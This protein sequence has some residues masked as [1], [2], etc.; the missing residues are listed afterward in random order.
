MKPRTNRRL[1]VILLV[2]TL[3]VAG[4]IAAPL[5]SE[6]R[7]VDEDTDRVALDGNGD[8]EGHGQP[9][10]NGNDSDRQ[11]ENTANHREEQLQRRIDAVYAEMSVEERIAQLLLLG[12]PGQDP[13]EKLMRWVEERG[14]GGVKVFGWNGRN[15]QRLA[16]TLSQ[17]Q[18]AAIER[19]TGHGET[20]P[21][22]TV[23][24]Q[25]GGWVRHVRGATSESPGNMAIG[26]TDR[27]SDAFEAAR[28]IAREMKALG[29]NVNLAP[30]VDVYRNAAADVIGSRAFGDDPARSGL[31]G[32][33]YLR[34]QEQVG[35]ISTAKHFPGHGNTDGDSHLLL[36]VLSESREELDSIDLVPFRMMIREGLPA[37][38][39]GHLA[40]PEITGD[41]RPASLSPEIMTGI[42]RDDLGFEGIAITDD[43]H[44]QGAIAY[45]EERGWDLGD[46][47][48]RAIEAGNDLIMLSQTPDLDGNV[49]NTLLDAYENR[50][51][52]SDRVEDAVMRNLRLKLRYL[53][54]GSEVLPV[55]D[56][57]RLADTLSSA[58]AE[59]FFEDLARR[60]VSV[61][62]SK[63]I[64]LETEP[65]QETGDSA[66]SRGEPGEGSSADGSASSRDEDS[67]DED[68]RGGAAE[69]DADNVLLAGNVGA[70]FEAGKSVFPEA[71][72]FR[73]P[74]SPTLQSRAED[75]EAVVEHA[76]GAEL[77]VFGL[78][79]RNSLEVLQQL[80]DYSDRIVVI[81]TLSPL[82]LDEAPFVED[83]IAVY[84]T[85]GA[86]FEAGF[87]VLIGRRSA[88]GQ[89]PLQGVSS[90]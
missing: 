3:I 90:E 50:P 41:R 35:V 61:V 1:S 13:S 88:Q 15:T 86:S 69:Y 48:V 43:M 28:H 53:D 27:P 81:S 54:D 83:A 59:G 25:E 45:G 78:S 67:R 72:V 34:G 74:Y 23:T 55:S 63:R 6:S 40:F 60:A 22:F 44:M 18:E 38:L 24:D 37:V 52:F 12:W 36:P 5:L 16:A 57:E 33:A 7:S 20:L 65:Q 39:S 19:E 77:I 30:V 73:F 87:E 49:W 84:S 76:K 89:V 56:N 80:R 79:N 8:P 9:A 64:P 58:E 14:I 10:S 46:L 42:L 70:F 75:R 71:R 47:V 51:G 31:L 82:L 62:R 68:S 29:I 85:M 2:L 26:A 4:A 21:L 66:G 32:V 17:L 11:G